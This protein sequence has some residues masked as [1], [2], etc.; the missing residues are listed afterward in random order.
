MQKDN[1]SGDW[2]VHDGTATDGQLLTNAFCL[3][4]LYAAGGGD[5]MWS[6]C[7]NHSCCTVCSRAG[8]EIYPR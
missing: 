7:D 3:L 8:E 2:P 5:I 6:N 1:C 4:L